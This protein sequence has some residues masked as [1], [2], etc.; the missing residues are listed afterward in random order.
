MSRRAHSW[1]ASAA[2]AE[3][4]KEWAL[5]PER[6][7]LVEVPLLDA[8]SP[9]PCRPHR[10]LV[11]GTSGSGKTTLAARIGAALDLP[12]TEMDALH[13]GPG[14]TPRPEF[15]ADVEAFT[16]GNRWATEWQYGA[17]RPLLAER[18]DLLVWLDLPRS[19]VM[20]QVTVRTLRR[21][22][23]REVLWNGNIEPPLWTV[24]TE[25]DH[26]IRWAWRTHAD[27][28]RKIAEVRER[29]EDLVIVRLQSRAEVED[30]V[31]RELSRHR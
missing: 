10:V 9:L 23:R 21:R 6:P 30:W 1:P 15:L 28:A 27:G 7:N 16:S 3:D 31:D 26:I 20:R 14:W 13:H 4:E 2:I 19:T 12:F 5:T 29:L 24:F 18:A 8:T 25:R 11:A 17:A 22:M